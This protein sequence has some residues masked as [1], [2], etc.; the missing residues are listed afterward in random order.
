M[1]FWIRLLSARS[2]IL[3]QSSLGFADALK[4]ELLAWVEAYLDC[5]AMAGG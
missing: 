4:A 1:R 3:V 2:E 5:P